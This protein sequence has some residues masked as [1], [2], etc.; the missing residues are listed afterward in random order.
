MGIS[1]Y[2]VAGCGDRDG[3]E[4]TRRGVEAEGLGGGLRGLV[5]PTERTK[6]VGPA[7]MVQARPRGAL[8]GSIVGAECV[9]VA[10]EQ[11]ECIAPAVPSPG[12]FWG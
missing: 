2:A 7:G 12:V 9:G 10:P 4:G 6:S 8:H 11:L 1:A 3:G 5:G